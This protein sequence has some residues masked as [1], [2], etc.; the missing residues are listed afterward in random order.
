M[1]D[2]ALNALVQELEMQ[3]AILGN[4]AAQFAASNA[5]LAEENAALKK[6]VAE[7]EAKPAESTAPQ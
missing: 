4:R 6:R 5:A 7:L 2:K 3:R 1:S